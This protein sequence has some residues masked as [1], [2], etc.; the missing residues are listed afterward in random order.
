[1]ISRPRCPASGKQPMLVR[2][3]RAIW[4]QPLLVKTP[5]GVITLIDIVIVAIVVSCSIWGWGDFLKSQFDSIDS[6]KPK[7][8]AMPKYGGSKHVT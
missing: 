6:A 3:Y 5:V 2:L 7:K 4:T 8:G 1:M